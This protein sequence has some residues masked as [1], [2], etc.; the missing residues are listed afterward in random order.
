MNLTE[1][2]PNV[3]LE[4]EAL[5]LDQRNALMSDGSIRKITNML[6]IDGDE[7]DDAVAAMSCVVKERDDRWH[8]LNLCDFR[9]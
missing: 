1:P 7:T 9:F 4:V 3:G 5:N 8:T 2:L 6:D